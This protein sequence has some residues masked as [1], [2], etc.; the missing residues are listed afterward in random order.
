MASIAN[1]PGGRR[2]ILVLD[3]NGDRKTIWLGKVSKR[4][5]EEIKTRVESIN[6]AAIAGV[7]IDGETAEWV[8]KIGNPLYAKLASAGLVTPRLPELTEPRP[9]ARLG[10]FLEGYISGR[11]DV[12]ERTR[13][14]LDAA[15]R[16]LVEYFGADKLLAD[17]TAGD[18][19]AWVIW[20]KARYSNGTAGR[21]VNRAK[22]FFRAAVRK[23]I[24]GKNPFADAKAPSQVNEARKFFVTLETAYKVLDACPDAEWRLIFA[25]SRFGGLRCPSEHLA[26]YRTDRAWSTRRCK[27]PRSFRGF[28]R[29][30]RYF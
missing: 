21:T 30:Y 6:S 18:A 19:D 10:V 17:I 8:G 9:Q 7:S 27:K 5:A 11:T 20:L 4:L 24:I 15:R 25:L 16:R 2:R 28:L 23:E 12:R 26:R 22:Q 13:I 1:D 29:E 3:K 14:N